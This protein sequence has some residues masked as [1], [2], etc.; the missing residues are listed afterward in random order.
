MSVDTW[1]SGPRVA[2]AVDQSSDATAVQ[3]T[4][5]IEVLL[6]NNKGKSDLPNFG[7][8]VTELTQRCFFETPLAIW[9]LKE[10]NLFENKSSSGE[11]VKQR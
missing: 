8:L 5:R 6:S 10:C 7:A 9:L 4:V 1:R 3:S 11:A 2:I